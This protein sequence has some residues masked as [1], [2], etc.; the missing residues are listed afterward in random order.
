[1]GVCTLMLLF[2]ENPLTTH[3][4]NGEN[5]EKASNGAGWEKRTETPAIHRTPSLYPLQNTNLNLHGVRHTHTCTQTMHIDYSWKH[6]TAGRHK[7]SLPLERSKDIGSSLAL[8]WSGTG[9]EGDRN[10]VGGGH[11]FDTQFY[12]AYLRQT[13]HV[14]EF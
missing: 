3:R 8:V 12:A 5:P 2:P 11:T 9:I 13:F 7:K 14:R 6:I 1:M 10:G 4:E